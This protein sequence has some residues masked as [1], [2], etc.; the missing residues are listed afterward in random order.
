MEFKDYEAGAIKT[1]IYP[2]EDKITLPIKD[3]KSIELSKGG[4]AYVTLGV[5]GEAG[6]IAEK[7]KKILRDNPPL[8]KLAEVRESLILE[9]G[10]V[11]WYVAALCYELGVTLEEVAQA[12]I[13]KLDSR[14]KRD[15]LKGSGDHR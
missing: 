13:N 7:V 4:L 6:E 1:L 11:L 10:D 15:K 2:R 14:K 8:E 9:A 12:N 5:N 3:G